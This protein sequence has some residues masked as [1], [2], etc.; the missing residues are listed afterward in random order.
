MHVDRVGGNTDIENAYGHI[1]AD[2]LHGDV[3]I[4]N[5]NGKISAKVV[6]YWNKG[7]EKGN[8]IHLINAMGLIQIDLPD[9]PS[10]E[11]DAKTTYGRLRSDFN[12]PAIEGDAST[13]KSRCTLGK[14]TAKIKLRTSHGDISIVKIGKD[15]HEF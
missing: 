6:S 3:K 4:E 8:D 13:H 1:R 2:N 15:A 14:G 11:L 7:K 9:P 12:L 5:K 10:F